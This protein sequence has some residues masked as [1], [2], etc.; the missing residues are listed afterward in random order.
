MDETLLQE[1]IERPIDRRRRR[2]PVVLAQPVEQ[3]VGLDRLARR[4]DQLEH[5]PAQRGE[6]QAT[7]LAGLFYRRDETFRV[8]DVV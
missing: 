4:G 1:E 2:V 6:P 8:L 5:F 3:I 7:L